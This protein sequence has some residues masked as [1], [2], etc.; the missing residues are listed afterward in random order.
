MATMQKITTNL[1]FDNQAEEAAHFYLS[2]FKNGRILK[3]TKFSE[4]GQEIHQKPA[5]SIMTVEYEM[6]GQKFVHLNGGPMFQFTEAISFIIDC[7]D[8][9]EIDYYWNTLSEGADPAAQQCGW[10]KDKYGLSWQIVPAEM[11]AMFDGEQS[12]ATKRAMK[13]ML[14]M[15]KLDIAKLREAYE[16]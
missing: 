13:A 4:E 6:N 7:K 1:W 9:E 10:L 8:Q 3:V 12:N 11:S 15:K 14:Q 16:G 2:V 5:G